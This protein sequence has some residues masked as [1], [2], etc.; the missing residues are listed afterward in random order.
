MKL[1][2][3]S[4]ILVVS[5]IWIKPDAAFASHISGGD[6]SYE[7]LGNNQYK[8][9]LNLFR[10]CSGITMSNQES[11]TLQSSCGTQTLTADLVNP[12][13]TEISQLCA[14]QTPNSTCN[15]GNLPGMERYTYEVTATMTPCSD[16]VISWSTCCRNTTVNVPTSSGDGSYIEAV[17][18]SVTDSCN[19][20]PVF[21]SQPIPYVCAN[22]QV[23]YNWGI[24]ETDGD[25]LTYQLFAARNDASTDLTYTAPY[26]D[27]IPID[28]III[29]QFTG[30]ITFTPTTIGNFIVAVLVYEYDSDGNLLGTTMRDIQFVVQNCSNTPPPAGQGQID[31]LTGT[32]NQTGGFSLEL[33][34]GGSFSFN[35]TIADSNLQDTITLTSNVNTVL[36]GSIFTTTG[37]NPVTATISWSPPGGSTFFNYFTVF[38]NDGACPIA[39]IQSYVYQVSVIPGTV[40]G[41]DTSVLCGPQFVQLG[42]TGGNNFVWS[43]ISGDPIVIG[44]NFTCDSCPN[45]IARPSFTTFYEV[46]SD[47]T[48]ST[49]VNRDTVQVKVVPDFTYIKTQND[50]AICLNDQVQFMVTPDSTSASY[51]YDW[52]PTTIFDNDSSSNPTATFTASG[53]QSVYFEVTSAEG[54]VKTD[55][56]QVLVSTAQKPMITIFADTTLCEGDSTQLNALNGCPIPASCGLSTSVCPIIPSEVTVGTGTSTLSNTAYPAPYGN[57]YEGARHQMLFTAAELNALGFQGGQIS[58]MALN[59]ASINGTTVYNNFEIKTGCTSITSLSTWQTGLVTVF[60]AQTINI[61]SGW[62]THTFATSYDW[63]GMSNIVIEICYNNQPTPWTSNSP[64]YYTTTTFPSVIWYNA[65]IDPNVCNSTF[66][67]SFSPNNTYRPNVKFTVRGGLPSSTFDYTWF[68]GIWLSDSTIQNPWA[69][70]LNDTSYTVI[71]YDTIGGCADTASI[72]IQAV[73]NFTYT[74]AQSDTSICLQEQVQFSVLPDNSSPSYTYTWSPGTV[75]NNTAISD[76]VGT[77]NSPGTNVVYFE[78]SNDGGCEK[79]DSMTVQVSPSKKP[80]VT[81]SGDTLVCAGDSTQLTALD[82]SSGVNCN[83]TL[84]MYDSFGDG[85]NGATLSFFSNGNLVGT[86]TFSTGDSSS[87]SIPVTDGSSLSI[88]FASGTYPA[89]ES[90]IL[91]DSQGNLLF[92][93]GPTPANGANVWTGTAD[94]PGAG[95]P[96]H[97]FTWSPSTWLNNSSIANPVS[98]PQSDTVYTLIV[99]DTVGGCAD[100][101]SVNIYVNSQFAFQKSQSNDSICLGESVQFT[102]NPDSGDVYAFQWTPATYLNNSAISNPLAGPMTT[103]GNYTYVFTIS[104]GCEKTD[105]MKI[106]VSQGDQPVVSI[107][108]DDSICEGNSTQLVAASTGGNSPTYSFNWNNG[109]SLSDS[110]ISN[111]VADPPATTTYTVIVTDTIGHCADTATFTVGV[112][113]YPV[114][115]ITPLA[116]SVCEKDNFMVLTA[117][118]AGGSWS[119]TGTTVN[120]IFAPNLAGVGTHEVYYSVKYPAGSGFGCTDKDTLIINVYPNPSMPTAVTGDPYCAFSTIDSMVAFTDGGFITW[121]NDSVL[122]DTFYYGNPVY[123]VIT[124]AASFDVW[125]AE[126]SVMGCESDSAFKL[127]IEVIPNPTASFTAD[128]SEGFSPLTVAFT[129]TSQPDTNN[130]T[131]DFAGLGSSISD[132]P[133]FVFNEPG[134]YEVTLTSTDVNGCLDTTKVTIVVDEDSKLLIP[135]IFTPNGDGKNDA[136]K[137]QYTA[138]T[139]FNVAIFSRWGTKVYESADPSQG[140]DG[141]DKQGQEA[142]PGVYFYVI[143]AK[144]RKGSPIT[145]DTIKG[146]VTLMRD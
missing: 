135:N 16:W 42:A 107:T 105:S 28:G 100:T 34:D 103:A 129:N 21:T 54:C 128:P 81:I 94:C 101:T 64:T 113:P 125:V 39:G 33:C 3:R 22:V 12:G 2:L 26:S 140:W 15:G 44:T 138:L 90:Y 134:T 82:V 23:I 19:N 97:S 72:N 118:P 112:V 89:E 56:M 45:P 6:I 30:Q 144:D 133:S 50:S 132:D 13:G 11:I 79:T 95:F 93:D 131:W 104:N 102:L 47:L 66:V 25:S 59:I 83:Y 73:P 88:T 65:D 55:T 130:F 43:V 67:N 142:H 85:W 137:V 76:P 127:A 114:A 139:E 40:A 70:P 48:S 108:A 41:P 119:G 24:T 49:C 1:L 86:Y 120:G 8:I 71:V 84:K 5:A 75:L 126:T 141:K 74:K 37:I 69:K 14:E 99:T 146:T 63:D 117:T 9:T 87:A 17:M 92:Q 35:I 123:D 115:Q 46:V 98:V 57:W 7:C 18:N 52:T 10:D 32:A 31:N 143:T 20:S 51:V 29:D 106:T 80:D 61:T 53:T 36:P 96:N 68:P 58:A 62:N 124:G 4:V 60:P 110:T 116:D 145:D 78:I 27:T 109:A 122:T 91:Y 111:P 121:Y 77:F 38:A 136:F